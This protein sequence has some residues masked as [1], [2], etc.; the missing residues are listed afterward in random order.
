[1]SR[2]FT[3]GEKGVSTGQFFH[4][5]LG[6]IQLN[7]QRVDWSRM[8][9]ARL[10]RPRYDT[11]LEQQVSAAPKASLAAALSGG[12]DAR[13]MYSSAKE[14]T[15]YCKRLGIMEDLKVWTCLTSAM[16]AW[17]HPMAPHG[18]SHA[19]ICGPCPLRAPLEPP[20]LR[21]HAEPQPPPRAPPRV[22]STFMS[23]TLALTLVNA[24][25]RACLGPATMVLS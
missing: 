1:M 20:R 5:Y 4:K 25:R 16:R 14:F 13:V 17:T 6:R 19:F 9:T 15:L 2:T 12:A 24:S 23:L 3:F 21:R 10:L 7:Q 8:Y 18:P 11:E 22:H